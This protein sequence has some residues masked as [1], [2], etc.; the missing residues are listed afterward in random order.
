[1]PDSS[2]SRDNV[3]DA[4]RL[5]KCLEACIGA[6]GRGGPPRSRCPRE[7]DD[8]DCFCGMMTR[9]ARGQSRKR[10]NHMASKSISQKARSKVVEAAQSGAGAARDIA[11]EAMRAAAMAAA[12]V[13]LQRTA[14]ALRGTARKAEAAAPKQAAA[15]R[16]RRKSA[17]RA[18][19]AKTKQAA[20]RPAKRSKRASKAAK[21]R[22]ARRRSSR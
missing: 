11:Q 16:P 19:A 18:K 13:A 2:R 5:S 8:T 17:K 12:G 10:A 20:R 1:M 22:T 6:I 14:D 4:A 15:Q 9:M 3:R 21:R 7:P